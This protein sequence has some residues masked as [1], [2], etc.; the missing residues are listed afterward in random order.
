MCELHAPRFLMS[1]QGLCP[2]SRIYYTGREKALSMSNPIDTEIRAPQG[3]NLTWLGLIALAL[4]VAA[5]VGL[6]RLA[7]GTLMSRVP[8]SYL[9]SAVAVRG[10]DGK[11]TIECDRNGAAAAQ[12]AQPTQAAQ[13]A[14]AVWEVK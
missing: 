4:L 14:P 8:D 10:A 7:D 6:I 5:S 13:P 2:G 1:K 12:A 9:M 3:R 11:F